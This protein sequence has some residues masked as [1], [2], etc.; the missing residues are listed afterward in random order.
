MNE[1]MHCNL[2][3]PRFN[4]FYVVILHVGQTRGNYLQC[5]DLHAKLSTRMQNQLSFCKLKYQIYNSNSSHIAK[6]QVYQ[7]FKVSQ[8]NQGQMTNTQ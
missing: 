4:I 1:K 8:N 2:I 6:L 3:V 5:L 7:N